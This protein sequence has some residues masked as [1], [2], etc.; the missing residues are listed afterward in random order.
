MKHFYLFFFFTLV[1]VNCLSIDL[2]GAFSLDYYNNPIED[3]APSPIQQR[4]V[5]FHNLDI[6]NFN[7]RSGIGITEAN[8]EISGDDGTPVFNDVYSGFYTL[9]FDL[10]V[11][12]GF[13]IDITDNITAGIS[14]G[15]GVR[16]PILTGVDD[17]LSDDLDVS[18]AFNW[19][20]SDMRFLFWSGGLFVS[21]K[22][23]MSETTRFFGTV[24][25]KDFIFRND[26]WIIGAT[27]G[28]LWQI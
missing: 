17:D 2:G 24:F 10:F 22:L 9:E 19:F 4:P 18:K 14:L 13:Q 28:L 21:I 27:A 20:Y 23:P 5:V 7:L 11:Y 3:S 12:P 15:G 8:Y 1:I 25:Y 26:Q 16:L 6:N